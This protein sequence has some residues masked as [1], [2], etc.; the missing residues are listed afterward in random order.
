MTV[1]IELCI[2][3]SSCVCH[4]SCPVS[5]WSSRSPQ[6]GCVCYTAIV[7]D[8]T[9]LGTC[10]QLS[11]PRVKVKQAPDSANFGVADDSHQHRSIRRPRLPMPL[12]RPSC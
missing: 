8:C 3:I 9:P 6:S 5:D 1:L 7:E 12:M 4:V 11:V 10:Y 2:S